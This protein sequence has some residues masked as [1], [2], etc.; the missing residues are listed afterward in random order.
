MTRALGAEP[1]GLAITHLDA[2]M[3]GAPRDEISVTIPRRGVLP[4]IGLEGNHNR[5]RENQI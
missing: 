2:D 4:S 5:M 1:S 3:G